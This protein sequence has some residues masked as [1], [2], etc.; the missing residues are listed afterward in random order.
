VE[1]NLIRVL[2]LDTSSRRGSVALVE[3]SSEHDAKVCAYARHEH[4]NEHAERMLGL[5]ESALAQAGWSRRDIEKIAVGVGPGSFTGVRIG[6]AI[7]QG[8]M[9]G[10]S[11]P[12]VGIGSLAALAEGVGP[13]DGRVRFVVRD[14]RREEFFVAAYTK[15]G[16]ELIAPQAIPQRDAEQRLEEM[17]EQ[18]GV[19]HNYVLVGTLLNGHPH[20]DHD[21]IREPDARCIARLG[22]RAHPRD[23]PVEPHYVRGPNLVRPVL[24]PNPLEDLRNP[25]ED[26]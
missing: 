8:L 19:A 9:L 20:V 10:L 13:A 24:L 21:E 6:L 4:E 3:G 2:A 5:V 22:Y 26:Q 17:V 11:V 23:C 18:L 16:Q 15:E 14:A 1:A 7:A 25:L 12:G